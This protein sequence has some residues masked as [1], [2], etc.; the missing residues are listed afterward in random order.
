MT[1]V[2]LI[3]FKHKVSA[4]F[5]KFKVKDENKS[6]QRLK[7]LRTDGGLNSTQQ[8]SR[9]SMRNMVLNMRCL[10]HT[11]HNIMVLLKEGI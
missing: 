7:I 9:S 3:K 10:F 4:E 2:T 5:N 8:S 11:L 6:G 1:W